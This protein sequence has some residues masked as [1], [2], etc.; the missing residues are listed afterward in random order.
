M[1]RTIRWR[2]GRRWSLKKAFLEGREEHKMAW[3]TLHWAEF[4]FLAYFTFRERMYYFGSG[5]F[6]LGGGVDNRTL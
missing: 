2:L 3:H 6:V 4:L 1:R 5:S